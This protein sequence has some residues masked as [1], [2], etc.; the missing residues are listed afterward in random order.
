MV[1]SYTVS[2]IKC[3]CGLDTVFSLRLREQICF[4]ISKDLQR[5]DGGGREEGNQRGGHRNHSDG[6]SQGPESDARDSKE[7][8][9]TGSIRRAG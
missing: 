6:R 9:L 7:T 5:T 2:E 4:M 3:I 1:Q 8:E